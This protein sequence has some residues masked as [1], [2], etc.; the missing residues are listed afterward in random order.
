MLTQM[1]SKYVVSQGPG[2]PLL[3]GITKNGFSFGKVTWNSESDIDIYMHTLVG[4][5]V[6]ILCICVHVCMPVCIYAHACLHA[7]VYV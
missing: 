1:Y 7:C 5:F 2:V 3:A 6:H 4:I